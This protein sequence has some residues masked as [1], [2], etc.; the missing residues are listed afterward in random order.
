MVVD[1]AIFH[2]ISLIP[3]LQAIMMERV[4]DPGAAE[5]VGSEPLIILQP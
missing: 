2:F 1:K 5:A 3:E 4:A